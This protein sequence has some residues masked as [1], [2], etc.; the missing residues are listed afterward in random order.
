MQIKESI[1]KRLVDS[2][3]NGGVVSKP[4]RKL[5]A[6]V[7]TA[8]RFP[9]YDIVLNGEESLMK[10]CG[11]MQFKCI[12]DV[13][14]HTGEWTN[15]C[16][17]HCP[18]ATYF[19][20]EPQPFALDKLRSRFAGWN[21]VHIVDS[22]L[23]DK[24]GTMAF[25]VHPTNSERVS[26][27]AMNNSGETQTQYLKL[28]QGDWYCETNGIERIDF[29]KI[30]TEGAEH[31]VLRG[32]ERMLH[33]NA[34][35]LIQFEYGQANIESGFLLKH[36]YEL[37]EPLG[38]LIGKLHPS[39]VNFSDY[40]YEMEDFRGPNYVALHLSQKELLRELRLPT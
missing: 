19:V 8:N 6:I 26:L 18:N 37:L 40:S 20:F 27:I 7:E 25:N 1:Y 24:N 15:S 21:S 12:F 9:S 14:A 33:S 36:F 3:K 35:K 10:M 11:Q 22:G 30:D 38:F 16:R 32:F 13:G 17:K 2:V 31:M 28:V 34:I 23:S 29:L 5:H 4:L 39:G